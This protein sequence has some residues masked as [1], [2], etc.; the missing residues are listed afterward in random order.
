MISWKAFERALI[1]YR[2]GTFYSVLD[3]FE[4]RLAPLGVLADKLIAKAELCEV[5]CQ[6]GELEAEMEENRGGNLRPE[7]AQLYTSWNQFN[8]FFLA[9]SLVSTEA[10]YMASGHGSLAPKEH[11]AEQVPVPA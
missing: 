7:F 4:S 9:S 10:Y 2:T 1:I 8:E 6:R 3:E 11:A 5:A